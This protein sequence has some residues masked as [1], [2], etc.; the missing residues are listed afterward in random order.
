MEDEG[1]MLRRNRLLYAFAICTCMLGFVG[2]E[3]KEN[4]SSEQKKNNTLIVDNS[5]LEDLEKNVEEDKIKEVIKNEDDDIAKLVNKEFSLEE[6]Y[7]PDDLVVPN[8]RL[9]CSEKEERSHLR[10]VAAEALEEMFRAADSEGI[11]LCLVSAFRSSGYQQGLYNNSLMRRGQEYTERYIAKPN[12]S[13]HQTGLVADISTR[14][15]NY[16]LEPR[17]RYTVEGQWLANNA[18]KYGFILRY[19]E[20]REK[21]TGY[22]FEPWHFRYVGKELSQYIYEND[23]ILEDLY[24]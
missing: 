6:G 8:V 17:F 5:N 7:K 23:L 14:G 10:Y 4:I 22:S 19:K 20:G 24:K 9:Y 1:A 18:H 21:D 3:N 15:M 2:C 12:H 16:E 11:E 13:E